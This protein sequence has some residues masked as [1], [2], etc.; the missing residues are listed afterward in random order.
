M[1]NNDKMINDLMVNDKTTPT[2]P[3]RGIISRH[4]VLDTAIELVR[5]A[6]QESPEKSHVIIRRLRV[7]P[8]MTI[9]FLRLL[10]QPRR[11][12]RGFPSCGGVP[13]GR[14]GCSVGVAGMVF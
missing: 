8:A 3:Q 11:A 6:C 14:G 7:K 9:A 4:T 2:P 1:K 13:E 12:K 10:R 5:L